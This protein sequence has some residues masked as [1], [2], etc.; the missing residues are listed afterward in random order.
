MRLGKEHEKAIKGKRHS[1]PF[2]A[3][4]SFHFGSFDT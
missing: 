3:Y 1:D 4:D 2:G